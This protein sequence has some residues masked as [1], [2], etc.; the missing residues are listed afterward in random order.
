MFHD[1][2]INGYGDVHVMFIF[3][4]APTSAF[5]LFGPDH[6]YKDD[7][8]IWSDPELNQGSHYNTTTGRFC[9][10][11]S[12]TYLF[13]LDL[14]KMSQADRVQCG[15]FKSFPD[16]G[17]TSLSFAS[18]AG[19]TS[20]TGDYESSTTAIVHLEQGDCV[21]VGFCVGYN[22]MNF[23]TAFVGTLLNKDP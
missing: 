13:H 22:N 17:Q 7:V 21:Y 10:E 14:Y 19:E 23:A 12:G 6:T 15:I 5:S 9:P 11:Y 18:V 1:E 3:S 16:G 20:K 8:V 4:S 2:T